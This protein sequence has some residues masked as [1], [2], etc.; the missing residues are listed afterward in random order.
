MMASPAKVE[1]RMKFRLEAFKP[2]PRLTNAHT[3]NK[4][5]SAIA[6]IMV[7]EMI[8]RDSVII[9]SL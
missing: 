4:S 7:V 9:F 1:A 3:K 2:L 5:A 8:F 6:S